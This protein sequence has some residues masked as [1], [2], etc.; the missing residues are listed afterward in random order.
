MKKNKGFFLAE[1]II[2]LALVTTAIAFVLPNVTKL[3]ENYLN[4]TKLYDQVEDLY[5][6]KAIAGTDK[7]I[8]VVMPMITLDNGKEWC[9]NMGNGDIS[10]MPQIT[11]EF[12]ALQS[13][14]GF[15]ELYVANYLSSLKSAEPEFNR[16]LKR[17]KKTSYDSTSYRL[18]GKFIEGTETRYASIKIPNEKI[19]ECP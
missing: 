4:V 1:T 3:Y 18:I 5:A 8:N 7:F 6:L 17:L 14:L 12:S 16:Y 9:K 11:T 10:S 19:D 2:V 13:L 15:N